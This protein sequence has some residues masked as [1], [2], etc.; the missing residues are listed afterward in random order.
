MGETRKAKNRKR[1][2]WLL[3]ALA[4][5][6]AAYFLIGS[7]SGEEETQEEAL[8]AAVLDTDAVS[9]ISCGWSGGSYTLLKSEDQWLAEGEESFPLD[10]GYPEA[11]LEAAAEVTAERLVA[12]TAAELSQYGLTEPSVTMGFTLDGGDTVTYLLGDYN[13]AAQAYYFQVSGEEAVWLVDSSLYSAFAKELQD[14]SLT[15]D[16]FVDADPSQVAAFTVETQGSLLEFAYYE[17]GNPELY[18]AEY[19]WSVRLDGGAWQAA[20][21]SLVESYLDN[22][23]GLTPT[24]SAPLP[25][26]EAEAAAYGLD[27]PYGRVLFQL[28]DGSSVS[29]TVGGRDDSGFD[30]YA[31]REGADALDLLYYTNIEDYFGQSPDDFAPEALFLISLDTVDSMEVTIEQAVYEITLD[32]LNEEGLACFLNGQSLSYEDF[33]GFFYGLTILEQEGV[34]EDAI[35]EES[36]MEV[37]FRRNTDSFSEMILRLAPRDQNFY[38]VDFNG[39]TDQLVNKKYV[40]SLVE[41]LAELAG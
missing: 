28:T 32:R 35:S 31:Q 27:S 38:Q 24:G 8:I 16:S 23:T 26:T 15:A 1:L 40:D 14:M 22:L 29:F 3:G 12:E 10:P 30:Y 18:T 6:A 41:Y 17:N 25:Q 7:L 13:S 39:R 34:T 36:V 19:L 33:T 37:V 20:D 5:L 21:S 9:A 11:M 4:V 2:L